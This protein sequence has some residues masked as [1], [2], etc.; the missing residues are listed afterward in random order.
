MNAAQRMD[1]MVH[2]S[3]SVEQL[4]RRFNKGLDSLYWKAEGWIGGDYDKLWI[5]T[6]GEKPDR[7]PVEHAEVQAL[8]SRAVTP[9]W[10]LQAGARYDVKP[11]PQR[12]YAVLGVEGTAP[13]FVDIEAAAFVSHKG[14]VSARIEAEYDLLL[15]QRLVLQPRLETNLALQQVRALGVGVGS[16]TWSLGRGSAT[17]SCAISPP[18]SAYP[19]NGNSAGRRISPARKASAPA[20][21]PLS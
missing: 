6:E 20:C 16:A 3:V 9:T 10:D 14:D 21:Q 1:R 7:D 5:K 13:Y 2:S 11:R 18:M 4:E 12:V 8:W 19:G 15:T 17:R